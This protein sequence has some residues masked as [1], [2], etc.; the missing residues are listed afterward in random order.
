[1]GTNFRLDW[2]TINQE[3]AAGKIGMYT[4]GS[5]VYTA[6]VQNDG[7]DPAVYGLT[8]IPLETAPTPACS[9]AATSPRSTSSTTR[10][11]SATPPS[12]WIDFYYMQKLLNEEAAVADAKT[13]ADN[14]QPVGTPAAA[15]L[16]PGDATT[17]RWTG[18]RTYI[19]VPRDQ[20]TPFTDGIFEQTLVAEP[21]GTRRRSTRSSTPSCRPS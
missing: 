15:D 18:S 1:M 16:R 19:N 7:L 13:L 9:A 12:Q 4:G 11:P 2:G 20:M 17:S 6:L 5:D 21:T 3:F 14:D 8:I 10:R